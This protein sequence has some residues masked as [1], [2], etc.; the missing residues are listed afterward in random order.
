MDDSTIAPPSS[1]PTTN[2]SLILAA[3]SSDEQ[4][5]GALAKLCRLYWQPLYVFARRGGF[6]PADA[7]DATQDFF[8][9]MLAQDWLAQLDPEKGR[10]RGFLYQSMSFHLSELRRHQQA[11]KRGGR[12]VHVP[13]DTEAAEQRYLAAASPAGADPAAGFDLA[14]ACTIL[15]HALARLVA[16]EQAAGRQARFAA[17]QPFLTRPPTSGDYNRLCGEL[18]VARSTVAVLV[19]RLG[20]RYRELVRAVVADTLADPADLDAELRHLLRCFAGG[21]GAL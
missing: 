17:L 10:F 13:L 1:P 21:P 3:Q 20:R 14:W 18:G 4:R 12:A 19:H 15:D 16:E 5:A 11:E 2:W 8:A 9:K 6:A 7:E